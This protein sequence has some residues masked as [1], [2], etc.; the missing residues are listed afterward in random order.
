[1]GTRTNLGKVRHPIHL[2]QHS[3]PAFGEHSLYR[4]ADLGS[5]WRVAPCYDN[6]VA[7]DDLFDWEVAPEAP[8]LSAHEYYATRVRKMVFWCGRCPMAAECGDLAASHRFTGP[9]GGAIYIKGV[10]TAW[11]E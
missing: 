6:P 2:P 5:T 10:K 1:M 7:Q 3:H 8:Y 11:R 4:R 9:Y